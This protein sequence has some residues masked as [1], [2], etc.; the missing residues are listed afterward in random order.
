VKPTFFF[1]L[2]MTLK[3]FEEKNVIKNSRRDDG[4]SKKLKGK[5]AIQKLMKKMSR[6][7]FE[8]IS[9]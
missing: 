5:K 8:T 1:S 3:I 2:E 4:S 7:L 6:L 9:K